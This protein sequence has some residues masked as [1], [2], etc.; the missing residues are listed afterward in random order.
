MRTLL[1][2]ASIFFVC[3]AVL[4]WIITS[5]TPVYAWRLTIGMTLSGIGGFGAGW[6]ISE[7]IDKFKEKR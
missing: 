5:I 1:V 6:Y 7:T 3:I 2:I 4:G